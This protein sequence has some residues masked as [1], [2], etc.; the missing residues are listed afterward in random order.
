MTARLRFSGHESFTLRY[1]WLP[2]LYAGLQAVPDLFVDERA[3]ILHLGIGRNM[4][5]SLRFWGEACG[6]FETT[7]EGYRA[8]AMG[9]QLLDPQ[10]GRDPWLES[11]AS[12]WLLHWQLVAHARLGAWRLV[13]DDMQ[14]WEVLRS[15]LLERL[16]ARAALEAGGLVES[17][18]IQH[19]EVFLHTYA[20]DHAAPS[21]H[22]ED[23]LGA[24]L[25]ELGLIETRQEGGR[26]ALLRLHF[27]PKDDLEPWVLSAAVVDF[28]RRTAANSRSL[29]LRDL[30]LSSLSPGRVFRLDEASLSRGLEQIGATSAGLLI[31]EDAADAPRLRLADEATLDSL[32]PMGPLESRA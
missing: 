11:R 25:R 10:H 24:P 9:L 3:A 26:D 17:T 30:A 7:P 2:K 4:V 21:L 13:F 29:S 22:P 5:R 19:L 32:V 27:G 14:D 23:D 6:L 12:L 8:T 18:L 1:G 20:S 31:W 15:R 28:W 16:T